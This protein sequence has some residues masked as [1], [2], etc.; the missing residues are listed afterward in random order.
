MEYRA[1]E[2]I[3]IAIKLEQEGVLFYEEL[4]E[5]SGNRSTKTIFAQFA[6][7]EK[8]HEQHFLSLKREY[9]FPE[10]KFEKEELNNIINE[11]APENVLPEVKDSKIDKLHPLRAI[12]LGIKAEKNSVKFYKQMAQIFEDKRSQ[13]ILKQLIKEEKYHIKKLTELHKDRSFDF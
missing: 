13:E 10:K 11:I 6:E 12:K 7:D 1:I 4:A 3:D 9:L 2:L 5:K 8:T